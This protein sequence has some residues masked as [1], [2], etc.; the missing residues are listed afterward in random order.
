[1][2]RITRKTVRETDLDYRGAKLVVELFPRTV[3]IWPKGSRAE[4]HAGVFVPYDGIY[5][6]GLKLAARRKP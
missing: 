6:F 4:G 3:R 1:M 2:T 5:E